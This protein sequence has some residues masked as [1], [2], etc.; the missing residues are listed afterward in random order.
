MQS[1]YVSAAIY[2]VFQTS[3][4][5][6]SRQLFRRTTGG[7]LPFTTLSWYRPS[8][9]RPAAPAVGVRCI[10]TAACGFDSGPFYYARSAAPGRCP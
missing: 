8:V 4:G 2:L 3:F 1:H 7:I 10:P 6:L 9:P 5:N